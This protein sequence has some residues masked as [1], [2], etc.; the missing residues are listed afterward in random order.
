MRELAN[1]ESSESIAAEYELEKEEKGNYLEARNPEK[2]KQSAPGFMAS[3][4]NP[5]GF[6]A[7]LIHLSSVSVSMVWPS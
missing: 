3:R 2:A 7:F 6:P 5:S 4:F 1:E